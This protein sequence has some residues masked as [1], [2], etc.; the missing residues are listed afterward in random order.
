[1]SPANLG[2]GP[3]VSG[4]TEDYVVMFKRIPQ[5]VGGVG[6]DYVSLYPNPSNG[7]FIVSVGA[8]KNMGDIRISV[9]SITGKQILN[10]SYQAAHT[11]FVKE[12]DLGNVAKGVYFVEVNTVSGARMVQKLIVQ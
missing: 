4:E 5:H 6:I 3:Y 8:P 2:C 1:L 12:L 9:T 11:K 10:A 7:K